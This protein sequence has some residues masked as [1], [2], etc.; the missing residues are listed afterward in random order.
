MHPLPDIVG[1][2]ATHPLIAV[3]S[4]ARASWIQIIVTGSG[5]VRIG[6]STASSTVGLPVA[7]GGGF[8]LP[9]RGQLTTY[10]LREVQVYVPTGATVSAAYGE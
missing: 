10:S 6:D 9:Y 8:M 1:D 4:A 2:N 5:T 3:A 7:A